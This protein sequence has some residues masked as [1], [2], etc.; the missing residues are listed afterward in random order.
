MNLAADVWQNDTQVR[1]GGLQVLITAAVIGGGWI[2]YNMIQNDP[3]ARRALRDAKGE[4]RC[5]SA[6][7]RSSGNQP[8]VHYDLCRL[9]R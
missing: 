2:V 4:S 7:V 6:G 1:F 5:S 3:E 9:R 8:P